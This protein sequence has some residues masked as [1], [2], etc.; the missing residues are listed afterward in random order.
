[1]AEGI[2]KKSILRLSPAMIAADVENNGR[3]THN[4]DVDDLAMEILEDGQLLQPVGVT[5]PFR[6]G[7][8][9]PEDKGKY[10]LNFGFRRFQAMS[11][12]IEGGLAAGS[13][14]EEALSMIDCTLLS[15]EAGNDKTAFLFNLAE[16]VSR[17]PLNPMDQAYNIVKLIDEFG[18]TNAEAAKELKISASA[19]S[20]LKTL[21]KL[22]VSLHK[23]IASGRIGASVGYEL[24]R[25]PAEQ[26]EELAEKL[27]AETKA[28][29]G[30]IT[31][32]ALTEATRSDGEAGGGEGD[33]PAPEGETPADGK[34]SKTRT[35]I[36]PRSIK[37]A[38]S[39]LS[40][41]KLT[42]IRTE[43]GKKQLVVEF[44]ESVFAGVE[45]KKLK[46]IFDAILPD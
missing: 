39:F 8:G 22:P 28:T 17:E 18:M 9:R 12:I 36:K 10:R 43:K 7:E 34:P 6:K 37:A 38:L 4:V 46:K 1:M 44:V 19:A 21:M 41:Y 24:S 5:G 15:S 20:Q 35:P 27:L 40:I 32:E 14:G 30:K 45:E 3:R 42:D 25:Q 23:H 11:M 31:R 16:N 2:S 26:I 13:P 33:T 29:G